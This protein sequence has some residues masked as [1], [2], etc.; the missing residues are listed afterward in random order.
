MWEIERELGIVGSYFFRRS[1]WDVRFMHELV[2]AG[3]EVGY[4]YE[5]L[6]TLVKERGAATADEARALLVPARARLASSLAELRSRSSGLPLDVL[7]AHGDFA[8]R[9]V[10]V[11]SVELLAD[12]AF[13]AEI[14]VRLEAYDV[15]GHVDARSSDNS[16]LTYWSPRDPV[17]ALRRGESAVELCCIPAPGGRHPSPTPAKTS[18]GCARHTSTRCGCA[19]LVVEVTESR[20]G[21]SGRSQSRIVRYSA[22]SF[23]PSG[24]DPAGGELG[25][26]ARRSRCGAVVR[27]GGLAAQ[28]RADPLK[29]TRRPAGAGLLSDCG[30]LQ[31]VR[32]GRARASC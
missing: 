20:P 12:A 27:V 16:I 8:N 23:R 21:S 31:A 4:H 19:A 9:A 30:R 25:Q 29:T 17:E 14:G 22:V 15:E 26:R 10:G 3:Y 6:A 28:T 24:T 18:S 32:P 7:A 13:R 1:T 5:E 11:S 2:A